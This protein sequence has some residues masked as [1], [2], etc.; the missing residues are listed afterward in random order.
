MALVVGGL[1]YGAYSLLS[2]ANQPDIDQFQARDTDDRPVSTA[3]RGS[4]VP[5]L[6]GHKRLGATILWV[7]DRTTR[8]EVV[9]S[10]SVGGG[11]GS[12]KRS[13]SAQQTRTVYYESAWHG[14]CLGTG[15]AP[16]DDGARLHRIFRAGKVVFDTPI[17]QAANP[18]GSTF[19]TLDGDTFTIYWGE[20]AQ[21][22]NPFLADANRVGINSRWPNLL[23]VV[24]E[25]AKLGPSPVWPVIEYDI[26]VPCES[27]PVGNHVCNT[28]GNFFAFGSYY[29]PDADP[30][31]N[32]GYNEWNGAHVL[33]QIL[34]SQWPQGLALDPD[35]FELLSLEDLGQ[36]IDAEELYT[37]LVVQ[38]GE[39][40]K[41]AM[42]TLMSDLGFVFTWEIRWASLAPLNWS[43]WVFRPIRDPNSG[44]PPPIVPTDMVTDQTVPEI[45][46][47]F[48]D[49][50]ITLSIWQY[51]DRARTYASMTLAVDEDG[52]SS[53]LQ[54]AKARVL[55]MPTV[56]TF[57]Q[58]SRVAERRSQEALTTKVTY[59][60]YMTRAARFLAPG[61]AFLV[62]GIDPVLR[63]E[64]IDIEQESNRVKIVAVEDF[65]G[66][67]LSDFLPQS[68]G[69]APP[70]APPAVAD[71]RVKFQE[72]PA[73]LVTVGQVEVAKLRIRA[74]ADQQYAEMHL[75]RDNTSYTLEDTDRG[76][77]TGGDLLDPLPDTAQYEI[78]QGPTFTA[79]GPDI[80]SVE[81]LSTA[82]NRWRLG[83]QLAVINDE[84]FFLQTVTPLGGTTYRL[85][86]LIRARYNTVRGDHLVGDT[87]F[88]A[89]DSE[90]KRLFGPLVQPVEDLYIKG[91]PVAA[92][93]AL[94]LGSVV[95]V[96]KLPVYGLGVVPEPPSNLRVTAPQ[97]NVSAYQTGQDI[98]IEWGYFSQQPGSAFSG[99][100]LIN[101][102][103]AAPG[104]APFI[105][106]F[107]L[108]IENE[109]GT[110]LGRVETLLTNT[111]TYTNANL[112]S[113]FGSEQNIRFRLV[114]RNGGFVSDPSTTLLVELV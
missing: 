94:P 2:A 57:A 22:L 70:V 86:G 3:R 113:D 54:H 25:G 5:Y 108:Q 74:N 9:S 49:K 17:T 58:A 79:L 63:V 33:D 111:Y 93:G 104:L 29:Y 10:T 77:M 72:I 61:R 47:V 103:N 41:R 39:T 23:Y 35:R 38:S 89:K 100:G 62:V 96:S 60:I 71:L 55:R 59:T 90:I 14:V 7:G 32:G 16:I 50:P 64:T 99:A 36:V 6:I 20:R 40:A 68:S 56:T 105:G 11:K 101:A 46:T 67:E 88:I 81:D 26:E 34:F 24:W 45:A 97:V 98:T 48:D 112:V 12:K 52:E 27:G 42:E 109:L 43:R 87:V 85:D 83:E 51:R 66:N 107:F 76:T 75:S 102:G 84:I 31:L 92:A 28:P 15:G 13:S 65:Y 19:Q 21:P 106:D 80:A 82:V 78:A 37:S 44:P 73:E 53:F 91:Q 18:S 69:T 95:P 8:Q 4:F 110:V 30:A 1:T 114:H